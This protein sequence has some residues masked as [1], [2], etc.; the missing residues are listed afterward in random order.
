MRAEIKEI[1]FNRVKLTFDD[2]DSGERRTYKLFAPLG[3]GYVRHEDD[4][5]QVCNELDDLG[6]TLY[7]Y[8]RAPLI[9]LIRREYKARQQRDKRRNENF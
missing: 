3:G 1:A 5:R 2:V 7:W 4:N 8:G 6:N 9:D